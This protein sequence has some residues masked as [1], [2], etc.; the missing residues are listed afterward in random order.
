[1]S[2]AT[3]PRTLEN[4]KATRPRPRFGWLCLN[5]TASTDVG[6]NGF[7]LPTDNPETGS[8][9]AGRFVA[10]VVANMEAAR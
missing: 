3:K 6:A 2:V 9:Q 10:S 4:D 1:L 8:R 5:S 7:L